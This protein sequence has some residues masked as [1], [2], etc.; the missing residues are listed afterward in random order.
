MKTFRVKIE[1]ISP[2]LINRFKEEAE[3]PQKMKKSGKRDYG[4]PREQAEST[5]Y[6]DENGL[7]WIP[8]TWIKGAITSVSSD[9]KLPSSRKSVRS[10]IGGA[11]IPVEE[12]LYFVEKYKIGNC[13]VDAR[14]CVVQRARIMRYRGRFEKWSV[15]VN[16]QIEDDILDEDNVHQ[17]LIDAGRRCG[18]GDFRAQKGGPFGRFRVCNWEEVKS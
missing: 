16:L 1:G 4:T 5:L 11:V 8:A 14:P 3:I 10:V 13:E 15:E 9:Y 12:K 18:V 17:M 6:A 2:L 7:C